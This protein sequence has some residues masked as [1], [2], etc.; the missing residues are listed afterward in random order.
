MCKIFTNLCFMFVFRS[1]IT[2][3]ILRRILSDYFNYD[4]FYVMNVT[5]VD[6]KVFKFVFIFKNIKVEIQS[7]AKLLHS[8]Q[9]TKFSYCFFVLLD[10]CFIEPSLFIFLLPTFLRIGL[11]NHNSSKLTFL[12]FC[13]IL[14]IHSQ[15]FLENYH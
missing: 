7:N 10:S 14:G 13:M 15:I 9:I 4:I 5:D 8:H 3:D 1:Y 12:I 6:D 2:F 11:G